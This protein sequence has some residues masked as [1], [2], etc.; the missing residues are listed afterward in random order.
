M[1]VFKLKRFTDEGLLTDDIRAEQ[2]ISP[3]AVDN[4]HRIFMCDDKTLGFCF[5]CQPLTG[6]GEKEHEKLDQLFS[7]NFPSNMTMSFLLFRSPDIE[8]NLLV[9]ERM[10]MNH[11]HPLLTPVFKERMRW[12]RKHTDEEIV[13]TAL[14][15]AV[16]N[17][18]RVVDLKLI[19]SVKIPFSGEEPSEDDME[20]CL[21]WATKI[22]SVLKSVG[23]APYQMDANRYVRFVNTFLNWNA[24]A[25]WRQ[26]YR[27]L[28]EKDKPIP[29]QCFDP[30]SGVMIANPNFFGSSGVLVGNRYPL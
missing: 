26:G 25:T 30:D 10:R 19:V 24:R 12:L 6:G 22:V 5:E 27:P 4:E 18:G 28:W 13:G 20:D 11:R 16:F 15:G 1:D 7:Q 2:L 23:F 8:E 3:L 17:V 21:D 9:A 14:N 29:P